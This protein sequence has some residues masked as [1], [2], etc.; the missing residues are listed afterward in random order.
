MTHQTWKG[1]KTPFQRFSYHW[2]DSKVTPKG[3]TSQDPNT[4]QTQEN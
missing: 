2:Y 4:L 3:G 1:Y